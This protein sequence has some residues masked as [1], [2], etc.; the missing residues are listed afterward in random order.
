MWGERAVRAVPAPSWPLSPCAGESEA[1]LW[2]LPPAP[3]AGLSQAPQAVPRQAPRVQR[4]LPGGSTRALGAERRDRWGTGRSSPWE[5]PTG[6]PFLRV[7]LIQVPARP[8]RACR[9]SV[10]RTL[11]V[12]GDRLR[13]RF[14]P[15]SCAFLRSILVGRGAGGSQPFPGLQGPLQAPC[16]GARAQLHRPIPCSRAPSRRPGPQVLPMCPRPSCAHGF[17][18]VWRGQ[19]ARSDTHP[20]RP[21][22][23]SSRVPGR[24]CRRRQEPVSKAGR[25][26]SGPRALRA[27]L[28]GHSRP[29][30][31][32]A[33][34]PLPCLPD[35]GSCPSPPP[36]DP[37]PE[38]PCLCSLL[39]GG[40]GGFLSARRPSA[41]V[42]PLLGR[43]SLVWTG[44]G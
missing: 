18:T 17:L 44:G 15:R 38:S 36:S 23:G 30:V 41:R 21:T 16:L 3:R 32:A 10:L 20:S 2:G 1:S 25:R 39:S 19:T 14:I 5:V 34:S 22:P 43:R 8:W 11:R 4:G 31:T 28:G 33:C 27:L 37:L 35:R 13:S 6:G 26:L 40:G 24:V 9:R 7:L 12:W 29:V 42:P